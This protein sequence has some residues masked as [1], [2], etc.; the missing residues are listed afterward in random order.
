MHL[1]DLKVCFKRGYIN[2]YKHLFTVVGFFVLFCCFQNTLRT[3]LWPLVYVR[4]N[5]WHVTYVTDDPHPIHSDVSARTCIRGEETFPSKVTG[6]PLLSSVPG[7]RWEHLGVMTAH[8]LRLL[9]LSQVIRLQMF[10]PISIMKVN[11][12]DG[13]RVE[14]QENPP[15]LNLHVKGPAAWLVC[16][17]DRLLI[18]LVFL[19][20][21]TGCTFRGRGQ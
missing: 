6:I 7:T 3:H 15:Y 11:Y 9:V 12:S 1:N 4:N 21:E 10:S 8:R 17:R 14:T 2:S 19:K 20:E 13:W 18:K 16:L 5:V